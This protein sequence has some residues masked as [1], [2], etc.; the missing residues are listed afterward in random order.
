MAIRRNFR[1]PVGIGLS[2]DYIETFGIISSTS[3][4]TGAIVSRGGLGVSGN[5]YLG[6]NLSVGGTVINGSWAGNA[7]TGRYGGT[8]HTTYTKGD[9]IVGAGSTFIKVGIGASHQIL[10][11]FATSASGL[12][13]TDLSINSPI[14]TNYGCFYSTVT[15]PVL[16]ANTITPITVNNTYEAA[17]I[18]IFGGAG[19]SSRIRIL[20]GGVYNIQLSTQMN[21][22]SGAQPKVGD[23]WFR[24]NGT[25]VP[26]SNSKQ[27]ILG[28]DNQH[29]FSLNF[30]STF[31]AGQYFELMMNSDNDKFILEAT[32]AG[33]G[34]TRPGTPS[35]I[36]T[37]TKIL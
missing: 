20:N 12:G 7:I 28:Q 8:G 37:V 9:L 21:L 3:T 10:G 29:I 25:D 19:T 27:T 24:I 5:I 17:N 13:W 36:F 35:V 1:L 15:Q 4:S 18:E 32:A 11:Y 33:T 31:S 30:V 16:G 23:F 34:P 14:S 26:W 22:S 6:G 2:A